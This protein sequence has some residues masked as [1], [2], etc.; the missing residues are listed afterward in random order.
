VRL[1]AKNSHP[2]KRFAVKSIPTDII[3]GDIH[4]VEQELEIL[5]KA[6]HPNIINFYEIYKDKNFFHIVT[7][8]CEGGELFEH[9]LDKGVINE[10]ETATIILKIVSAIRHLHCMNICHRD[11]KP[12]NILFEYKGKKPEIKIIDFGLS[13]YFAVNKMTTKIGTPYYV[14]PEI[15]EGKYDK[16]CDMWSI[17]VITYIMLCGYP[18]FNAKTEQMLFKK[19]AFC[20]YSFPEEDWSRISSEAKDFITKLLEVNPNKRLDA[21]NALKHPWIEKHCKESIHTELD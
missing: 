18:P 17:G 16:N 3:R 11:L 13:K 20:D 14:S 2:K 8:F 5:K 7:E 4:M 12:E 15:L 21:E 19:I 10:K 1:A 9:I 6:D